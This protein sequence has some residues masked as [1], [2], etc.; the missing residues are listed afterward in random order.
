MN[1]AKKFDKPPLNDAK[2]NEDSPKL[3]IIKTT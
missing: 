2:I 1:V 3:G